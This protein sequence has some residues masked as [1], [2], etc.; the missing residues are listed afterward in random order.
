MCLWGFLIAKI[1]QYH[2]IPKDLSRKITKFHGF[3]LCLSQNS[4]VFRMWNHEIPTFRP[5]QI[6]KLLCAPHSFCDPTRWLAH[7]HPLLA[8][9]F[10]SPCRHSWLAVNIATNYSENYT[11]LFNDGN[12]W[13]KYAIL[14]EFAQCP[15]IQR[16]MFLTPRFTHR[17][18]R[19]ALR[20]MAFRDAKDGFPQC[21]TWSFASPFGMFGNS[22]H[23]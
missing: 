18:L 21:D 13:P 15:N 12:V 2:K 6:T 3:N 10:G 20:K 5:C 22:I 8:W 17:A 1:R 7:P 4:I 16:L 9:R 19:F 11:L 23:G 14:G